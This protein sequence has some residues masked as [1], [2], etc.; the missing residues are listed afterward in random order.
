MKK[1]RIFAIT[2]IVATVST[3]A[4]QTWSGWSTIAELHVVQSAPYNKLCVVLS[5]GGQIYK[6]IVPNDE[7]SKMVQAQILC[8]FNNKNNIRVY[9][10][11]D[12]NSAF[13]D[14]I[15]S[16]QTFYVGLNWDIKE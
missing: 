9:Y 15:H 13:I 3:F 5:S 14:A 4:G 12:V 2:I 11:D 16:N 6:N 1:L 10:D 7:F 8:A